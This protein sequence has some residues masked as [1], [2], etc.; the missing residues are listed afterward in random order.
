MDNTIIL[1]GDYTSTGGTVR[2]AFRGGVDWIRIINL[3][4]TTAANMNHGVE[5]YWLNNSVGGNGIIYCHAA[6]SNEIS[7]DVLGA[8]SFKVFNSSNTAPLAP[9]VVAGASN[10]VQP[11]ITTATTTGL[12]DG[13]I[14]R[15]SG[16]VGAESLDGFDFEIDTVVPA[17]SFRMRYAMA[18]AAGAAGVGGH[19]RV[20]PFSPIFYPRRRTIINITQAAA[21]VI[22]TSVQHGY[23]VGQQIRVSLPD[24][25]F[26]MTEIDGLI[27]TVIAVTASEITTDIDSTGF[28]AFTF[29]LPADVPFT[30]PTVFP[31]GEDTGYA[32]AAGVD[33]LGDATLDGSYIGIEC[34][35]GV[36]QPGGTAGDHI[37]WIAGKSF[38]I[39]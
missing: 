2:F 1:Q 12:E 15:L 8:A 36:L 35:G 11:I 18:N 23:V 6:A 31:Y 14:V 29:A 22:R 39:E 27:G 4:E 38:S 25:S 10:V 19:Y 34:P 16:S 26:G 21:A 28:T 37:V 33:I 9:V 24:A 32:L 13:S 3:T 20:V 5:Y 7:S 30:F 17:T